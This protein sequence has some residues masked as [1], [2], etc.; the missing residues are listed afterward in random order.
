MAS[1]GSAEPEKRSLLKFAAGRVGGYGSE[2]LRHISRRLIY[3]EPVKDAMTYHVSEL[4]QW[5][6]L[7]NLTHTV[8]GSSSLWETAAKLWIV[9][10]V[11]AVTVAMSVPDPSQMDVGK[12]TEITTFLR[13][14]VSLL[15]GFFMAASVKRWWA[16]VEAFIGLCGT[17]RNLQMMLLA[18]DAPDDEVQHVLRHGVVSAKLLSLELSV[19][20]L[21]FKE[22]AEAE[23]KGWTRMKDESTETGSI[24]KLLPREAKALQGIS[25]P[26]GTLWI[27]IG[28]YLGA[29][30]GRGHVKALAGPIF[31]RCMVLSS[32]GLDRILRVR[33]CIAVQAPFIYVQMLSSLVHISNITSAVSFGLTSGTAVA[34]ILVASEMHIFKFPKEVVKESATTLDLEAWMV[35][36]VF[37]AIGPVVYQALLE[38]SIAI[39]QPFSNSKALVPTDRILETLE[40]DLNDGMS[41]NRFRASAQ[42]IHVDKEFEGTTCHGD[43]DVGHDD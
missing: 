43:L 19:Q 1:D 25:D 31:A 6:S 39:A 17:V 35:A 38:V 13:V 18:C 2:S 40:N 27:W 7:C 28:T 14:F 20:A 12:F 30:A 36:F 8:W 24:A 4:S 29:M 16:C 34:K 10:T 5:T 3:R 11:I 42:I 37:G 33:S 32:Q 41:A 26:A 22:Q 9:S 21:P 23:E 15:L